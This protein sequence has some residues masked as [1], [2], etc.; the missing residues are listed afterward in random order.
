MDSKKLGALLGVLFGAAIV[1]IGAT[2]VPFAW[3][4]SMVMSLRTSI[5]DTLTVVLLIVAGIVI[6]GSSVIALVRKPAASKPR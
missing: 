4:H 2:K 1:V 6:I 3:N 5:G